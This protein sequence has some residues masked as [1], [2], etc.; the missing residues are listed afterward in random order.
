MKTETMIIIG[1]VVLVV[2]LIG[3]AMFIPAKSSK[4]VKENLACRLPIYGDQPRKAG[5]YR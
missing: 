3:V 2:V 4:P 5:V 1:V